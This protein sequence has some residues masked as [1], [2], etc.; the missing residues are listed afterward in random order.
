[1][2]HF[3]RQPTKDPKHKRVVKYWI[4]S[5]KIPNVKDMTF[6]VRSVAEIADITGIPLQTLKKIVYEKDKYKTK[7]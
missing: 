5:I 3:E 2:L 6:Q 1:M 7:K 4:V